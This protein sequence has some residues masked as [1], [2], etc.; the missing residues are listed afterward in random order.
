MN[1][2]YYDI[3]HQTWIFYFELS[4]WCYH[5]CTLLSLKWYVQSL[6]TPHAENNAAI[7]LHFLLVKREY[8]QFRKHTIESS[9]HARFCE[10][11][12]D[13][14]PLSWVS[15]AHGTHP[16]KGSHGVWGTWE[17]C[18]SRGRDRTGFP[19][20]GNIYQENRSLSMAF[21]ASLITS[22]VPWA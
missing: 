3:V 13:M 12:G 20:E 19:E 22:S 14:V 15:E 6:K 5:I 9:P 7:H 11:T 10:C 17:A 16:A 1:F 2:R 4:A 21:P 18:L 8:I